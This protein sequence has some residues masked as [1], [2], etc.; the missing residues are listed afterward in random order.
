MTVYQVPSTDFADHADAI[1]QSAHDLLGE[2]LWDLNTGAPSGQ[3]IT[4]LDVQQVRKAMLAV[5]MRAEPPCNFDEPQLGQDPPPLCASGPAFTVYGDN[6]DNP[7]KDGQGWTVSHD[8]E[9]GDFFERDWAITSELPDRSGKAFFAPDQDY[10]CNAFTFTDQTVVMHLESPEIVIPAGAVSPRLTFVHWFATEPGCRPGR[11]SRTPT[12]CSTGIP[13]RFSPRS[14]TAILWPDS[15]RSPERTTV[16]P[17]EPGAVRS[18]TWRRTLTPATKS[19]SVS[20]SATTPA[21]A[22]P[23]GTSTTSSSTGATESSPPLSHRG[24]PARAPRFFFP[25]ASVICEGAIH[26]RLRAA[27]RRSFRG[28]AGRAA[29]RPAAARSSSG[30]APR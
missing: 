8:G 22:G 11:S 16:R 18:S 20:I 13:K 24:A 29:R 7:V 15:A 23:A 17:A 1:E 9:T 2:N 3:R 26:A 30:C 21:A 28:E 19:A 10:T 27:E 5:E 12:S 14:S 4:G 25:S 6:F